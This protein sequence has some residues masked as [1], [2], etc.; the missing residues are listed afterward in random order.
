LDVH[1]TKIVAAVLDGESGQ[2]QMFSMVAMLPAQRAS[3]RAWRGR[4]GRPMR[5]GRRG[6]AWRVSWARAGWI[7]WSPRR[8]RSL[9]GAVI[10]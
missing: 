8:A 5:L 1:A 2:L 10:A 4:S 3:A 7:V 6:M 9:A